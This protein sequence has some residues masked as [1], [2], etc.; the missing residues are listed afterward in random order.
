MHISK[1]I[2]IQV[3]ATEG[4]NYLYYQV[5][6]RGGILASHRIKPHG[7]K[8][9]VFKFWATFAMVPEAVLVVYYYKPNGEIIADRV[10]LNFENHLNNYVSC[11]CYNKLG[12]GNV[13]F[14]EHVFKKMCSIE[15][16][17]VRPSVRPSVRLS[18]RPSVP[19]F[20]HISAPR[21]LKISI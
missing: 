18:V 2:R 1:F 20:F 11:N 16:V 8:V 6:G 19:Y 3:K 4:M 7:S 5:I 13:F 10:E 17:A 12:N 15:I 14:L 21:V 9:F